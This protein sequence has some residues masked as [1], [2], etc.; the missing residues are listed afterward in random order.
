MFGCIAPRVEKYSVTLMGHLPTSDYYL[1]PASEVSVKSGTQ[2][3]H[4]AGTERCGKWLPLRRPAWF[5]CGFLSTR[6]SVKASPAEPV[7]IEPAR[8]GLGERC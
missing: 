4:G 8:R 1:G 6:E 7:G 3:S 5:L 2:P